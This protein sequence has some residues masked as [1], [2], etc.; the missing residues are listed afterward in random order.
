MIQWKNI[1]KNVFSKCSSTIFDLS[2]AGSREVLLFNAKKDI[3]INSISLFYHEASSADAG[4]E[5]NFGNVA[6]ATTYW[7]TTSEASKDAG[8]V[9]TIEWVTLTKDI[10]AK[11]TPFII[12]NVGNKVGTWEIVVSVNY[13]V[14]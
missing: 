10:I 11:G 2:G 8:Y 14:L 12:A 13:T 4:I 1:D 3:K 6:S 7:A 9:K 5:I